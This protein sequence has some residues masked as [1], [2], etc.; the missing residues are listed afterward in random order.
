MSMISAFIR[1]ILALFSIWLMFFG[2]IA[3]YSRAPSAV[4]FIVAGMLLL[5]IA[6]EAYEKP[7]FVL[8]PISAMLGAYLAPADS[9][10]ILSTF[11]MILGIVISSRAVALYYHKKASSPDKEDLLHTR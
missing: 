4:L 6:Y 8:V 9:K 11:G 1:G 5:A 10:A 3:L 2:Y 7:L